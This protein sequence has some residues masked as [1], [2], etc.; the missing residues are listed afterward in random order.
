MN[1]PTTE[2]R[3][4]ACTA[5]RHTLQQPQGAGS[6]QPAVLADP[7]VDAE[8][9]QRQPPCVQADGDQMGQRAQRPR[10][11]EQMQMAVFAI[12]AMAVVVAVGAATRIHQVALGIVPLLHRHRSGGEGAHQGPLAINQAQPVMESLLR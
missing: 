4:A 11:P 12:V 8:Q 1:Q 2:V 10:A 9:R 7:A 3:I 6:R 5:Q